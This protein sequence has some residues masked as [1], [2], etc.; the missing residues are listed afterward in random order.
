MAPRTIDRTREQLRPWHDQY[1]SVAAVGAVVCLTL[2]ALHFVFGVDITPRNFPAGDDTASL[3][4]FSAIALVGVVLAACAVVRWW[5]VAALLRDG[6]VLRGSIVS[7]GD[8]EF[9]DTRE[10]TYAWT[11]ADQS[12]RTTISVTSAEA[13]AL[14]KGAPV[15]VLVHPRTPRRHLLLSMTP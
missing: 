10:V 1:L 9:E 15:S 4:M 13:A 5:L 6:V 7:F 3:V 11:H 8:S 14:K 12:H 2:S